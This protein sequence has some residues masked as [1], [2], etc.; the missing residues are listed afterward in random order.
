[1]GEV[2]TR[3]V[4]ECDNCQEQYTVDPVSGML[5]DG[6]MLMVDVEDL[7]TQEIWA[8]HLCSFACLASWA[9]RNGEAWDRI[10]D[11]SMRMA[12]SEEVVSRG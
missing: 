1:V 5:M 9:L 4:V 7:G 10:K 3:Q 12:A 11:A 2:T 6:D 8:V